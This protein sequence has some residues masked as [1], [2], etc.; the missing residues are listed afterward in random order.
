VPLAAGIAKMSYR[1]FF[2]FNVASA[3][4]WGTATTLLGYFLGVTAEDV[5]GLVGS[6]ATVLVVAALALI[7]VAH[8]VRRVVQAET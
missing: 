6:T 5:V 7:V 4:V 2:I 8:I 1:S 3:L